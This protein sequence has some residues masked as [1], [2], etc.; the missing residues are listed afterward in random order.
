M[1]GRAAR[2]VSAKLLSWNVAGRT[3]LLGEQTAAV[4]RQEPDLVCL[5][6]VRPST[7]GRWA[8]ALGEAGLTHALDSGEFRNDRRLFNL[9]ATGRGQ[10]FLRM[11]SQLLEKLAHLA[12]TLQL[13]D[14]APTDQQFAVQK[15]LTDQVAAATRDLNAVVEKD[16]AAFNDMLRRRNIGTVV[17]R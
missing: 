3:K 14:F 6:E 12:D 7:R 2:G 8:T 17:V 11:P 5:Q 16:V 10:D 15:L 1:A 4:T 9:T 13:A